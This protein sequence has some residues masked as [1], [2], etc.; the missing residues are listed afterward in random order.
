MTFLLKHKETMTRRLLRHVAGA[1]LPI[2]MGTMALLPAQQ[3]TA[4]SATQV[5]SEALDQNI[6]RL[7][8]VD[9]LRIQQ[10]IMGFETTTYLVKELVDGVPALRVHSVELGGLT[11]LDPLE[12]GGDFLMDPGQLFDE[13]GP[14][15]MLEGQGSVDGQ[16]TWILAL[17][18]F[19]G[20]DW[21]STVPGEEMAMTPERLVME[22]DGGRFV[23]LRINMEGSVEADG[24]VR[25]V[26]MSVRFSDY[27]EVDGY[28][29]PFLTTVETDLAAAGV[30]PEQREEA[31]QGLEEMRRQ[32]EQAP[33]AQRAMIERMLGGQLETL[34]R[35]LEGE[36]FELEIRVTDLQV[37]PG[38]P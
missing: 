28:L 20:I 10:Q 24:E 35:M 14:H 9:N 16:A 30:T 27:R 15:W 25:P 11:G 5:L 17:D 19:V 12:A 3:V 6:Q 34:E 4:Q 36:A 31:R 8:L 2:A 13:W 29:H 26:E 22:L 1:L 23:P 18:N 21:E 32:L 37:N 7:A 33:E 38:L